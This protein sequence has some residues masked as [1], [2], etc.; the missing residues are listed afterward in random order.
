MASPT[1]TYDSLIDLSLGHVPTDI[2]DPAVYKEL[3]DIHNALERMV[4]AFTD[5]TPGIVASHNDLTG[6][7]TDQHHNELH[8]IDSHTD[9]DTVTDPPV[10]SESLTW[11][12]TNWVPSPV[13][14]EAWPTGLIDGG[15][16][17]IS[18][19]TNIEVIA[20]SGVIVDSYTN[21]DTQ[22]VFTGVSWTTIDTPISV[23]AE[24]GA[25][26][27]FTVNNA[28]LLVQRAT[29]PTEPE[30][31]DEIVLGLAVHNGDT[32]G[33]ISSPIV[34]N[35]SAH[36][37]TEFLKR[38]A[39]PTFV[40]DGGGVTEAPGFTLDQ[41]SGVLWEMNRNWHVNKKDP[42]RE[43]LPATT[44]L[45]WRYVNRDFSDVGLLTGTVNPTTWD[46]AGNVTNVGGAAGTATIQ[47]LYQDPRDNYWVLWGQK[48]FGSANGL[49]QAS[50]YPPKY[51]SSYSHLYYLVT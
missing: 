42:H 3:L 11:D 40:I 8:N 31:R 2:Q 33:E 9:V 27:Y 15:E 28:G 5:S 18:G 14:A 26:V 48:K 36:T 34:L 12:G 25:L 44:G 4:A 21:P 41:Q 51:P 20:G 32:W 17:N 23:T 1:N 30:R 39:G 50:L 49:L 10:L 45:Q 16:L 6:I 38:V 7:S 37:L 47:Q 29:P 19:G 46:D 43:S 13:R 24:A 22:P 35:N